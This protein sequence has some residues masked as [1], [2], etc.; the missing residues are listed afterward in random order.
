MTVKPKP[1]EYSPEQWSAVAAT[2]P[3]ELA[4]DSDLMISARQQLEAALSGY[5]NMTDAYGRRFAKGSPARAA[6]QARDN[7]QAAIEY[8]EATNNVV[9]KTRLDEALK[10]I[11]AT[12]HVEAFDMLAESR[13]GRSDAAR[14]L[15]NHLIL[16]V[17][18]RELKGTLTTG[19]ANSAAGKR[20]A[21]SPAVRFLIAALK[22][23]FVI[24]PERAE[25]IV[26]AE[27]TQLDPG[28]APAF[29]ALMN[30]LAR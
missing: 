25:K 5:Q 6:Q 8:A 18:T 12:T 21:N 9:L 13:K 26:E 11:Y 30:R 19:R 4:A 2:V 23:L 24:G 22:P 27:R 17:W 15:L 29:F 16:K 10:I 14:D 1:V 7:I 3:A 20:Q 28:L